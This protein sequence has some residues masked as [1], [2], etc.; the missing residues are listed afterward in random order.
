VRVAFFNVQSFPVP[1]SFALF[2]LCSEEVETQKKREGIINHP[3]RTA[4]LSSNHSVFVR[5]EGVATFPME[6]RRESIGIPLSWWA[7]GGSEGDDRRARL[8]GPCSFEV[9]LWDAG[10]GSSGHS[11]SLVFATGVECRA[12]PGLP[13][14]SRRLLVVRLVVALCCATPMIRVAANTW[15]SLI[16]AC[17]YFILKNW[18]DVCTRG[19]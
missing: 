5:Q 3:H 10:T 19:G 1:F 18:C 8:T 14:P 4:A 17:F 15:L 9:A 2:S 6:G 7:S 16:P 11:R 13:R 12:H